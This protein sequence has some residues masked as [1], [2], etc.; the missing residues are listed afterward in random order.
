MPKGYRTLE[1]P[2]RALVPRKELK[3]VWGSYDPLESRHQYGRR[4]GLSLMR[5]LLL[6]LMRYRS[7]RVYIPFKV[8]VRILSRAIILIGFRI[9]KSTAHYCIL[10]FKSFVNTT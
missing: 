4:E 7:S 8:S 2:L 10:S 9:V 3:G 5:Q 1:A 6:R